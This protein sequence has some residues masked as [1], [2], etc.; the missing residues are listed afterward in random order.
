M[1]KNSQRSRLSLKALLICLLA[2][3]LIPCTAM[4]LP[5]NSVRSRHIVDGQVKA[6]DLAF[7]AI[8]TSKIK[9]GAVTGLKIAF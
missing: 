7:Q 2:G 3:F 6:K 9:D 4:A 8:K 5:Y 1:N